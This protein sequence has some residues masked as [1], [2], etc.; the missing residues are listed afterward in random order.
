MEVSYIFQA[1][2]KVN[3]LASSGNADRYI[4]NTTFSI[5]VIH[6]FPAPIFESLTMFTNICFE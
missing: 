2:F 5:P 1:I 6:T 4:R 3:P